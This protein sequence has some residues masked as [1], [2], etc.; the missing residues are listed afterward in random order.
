MIIFYIVFFLQLPNKLDDKN[1]NLFEIY[2]RL[3]MNH[4]RSIIKITV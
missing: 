1:Y 4:N 2:F 3:I